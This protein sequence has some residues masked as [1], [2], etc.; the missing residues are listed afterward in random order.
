MFFTKAT[1][2]YLTISIICC[3]NYYGLSSSHRG[4]QSK[5]RTSQ[6]EV[7]II[8]AFW[9]LPILVFQFCKNW[10]LVL[11]VKGIKLWQMTQW[12]AKMHMVV[13]LRKSP[14]SL[15]SDP[16]SS[17]IKLARMIGAIGFSCSSDACKANGGPSTLLM[18]KGMMQAWCNPKT[19]AYKPWVPQCLSSPS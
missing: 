2:V 15:T 9:T 12:A 5:S 6:E 13:S 17:L 7:E 14:G 4:P 8:S 10:G 18:S 16:S 1:C 3:D 11:Q 19:K